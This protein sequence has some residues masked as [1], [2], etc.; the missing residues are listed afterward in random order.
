MQRRLLLQEL[1][2]MQ[3]MATPMGQTMKLKRR[4]ML[5]TRMK[6]RQA[7]QRGSRLRQTRGARGSAP[8]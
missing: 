4:T 1:M 6:R 3:Q 2:L 8:G 7:R 5:T